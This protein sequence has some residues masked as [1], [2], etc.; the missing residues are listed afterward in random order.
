MGFDH[1]KKSMNSYNLENEFSLDRY[2]DC[3]KSALHSS[4]INQMKKNPYWCELVNVN[5][6]SIV[7]H[8]KMQL[9]DKMALKFCAL[10]FEQKLE[11]SQSFFLKFFLDCFEYTKDL[12]QDVI[13]LQ[14]ENKTLSLQR[15]FAL[16]ELKKAAELKKILEESL[17][18]KF[19]MLLN[20]KKAKIVQLKEQIEDMKKVLRDEKHREY[21]PSGE[22][23]S[24]RNAGEV[25]PQKGQEK[26]AESIGSGHP[27]FYFA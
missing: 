13:T 4:T 12:R 25:S 20:E 27:L 24:S 2:L 1:F 18:A 16:S 15:D 14:K 21:K 5:A 22:E 6:T 17:Y 8:C 9:T 23:L 19:I 10:L 11:S 26:A 7:I 3:I